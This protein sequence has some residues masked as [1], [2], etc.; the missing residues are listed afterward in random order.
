MLKNTSSVQILDKVNMY[1][2]NACPDVKSEAD[3][4]LLSVYS[5]TTT[6]RIVL[7]SHKNINMRES[8]NKT[9]TI[10][11]LINQQVKNGDDHNYY[12]LLKDMSKVRTRCKLLMKS[13]Y[14]LLMLVLM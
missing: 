5:S 1:F 14:I 2:V 13:T 3:V 12:N 7:A 11:A 8:S 4:D 10:S 9:K 6:F